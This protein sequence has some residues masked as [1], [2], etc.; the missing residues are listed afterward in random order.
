MRGLPYDASEKHVHKFFSPIQLSN[1]RLLKDDREKCSGLAFVDVMSET[2]LKEAMKRN[3]G[4]MGRQFIGLLVDTASKEK[5][6]KEK[7]ERPWE[8]KEDEET[9]ESIA[10]SGRLLIR[11]LPYSTTEEELTELFEEYG[12]LSEIN[13]LV[14]KSTGSS[15][16][17]GYVTFMFPERAVKAFSELDGSNAVADSIADQFGVRKSELLDLHTTQSL[18][19]RLALG[20]TKLVNETREFLESHSVKLNS[21]DTDK[22]EVTRR[23]KNVILVKNLPFGTST[24]ELT[25]LFGPFGSLSR[26]IL[27]PAGISALVEYSSSSNAKVAFKKLSYCEFKHLP[28]PHYSGFIPKNCPH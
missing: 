4:R 8:E 28:L 9:V 7:N 18:A 21:F 15:I 16:G 12:Q 20:E 17:L 14:D 24:E 1:I 27:P 6:V 10:D 11:N 2:D 3:K 13:L 25:E 5:I 22:D 23:S 19:V 26:I